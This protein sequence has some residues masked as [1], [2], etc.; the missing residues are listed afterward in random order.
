MTLCE[1]E[2]DFY[3]SKWNE[4]LTGQDFV[5]VSYSRKWLH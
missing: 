1:T 3:S 5:L 2:V 4:I